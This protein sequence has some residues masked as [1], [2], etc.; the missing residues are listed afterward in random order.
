MSNSETNSPLLP[1]KKRGETEHNHGY[2]SASFSSGVFSIS[3][4]IVGAGIMALPAT[5]LITGLIPG[6]VLIMFTG[7]L[8]DASLD[9]LLKYSAPARATT[10]SAV[11]AD[12]FG[13]TGQILSQICIIIFNFGLLVI[14]LIIMGKN[15]LFIPLLI[16]VSAVAFL[17]LTNC[18]MDPE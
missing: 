2:K 13:R 8:T 5:L 6:L 7:V 4:S 10:Y 14:Y 16:V 12:T 18:V 3:T 9:F 1:L 17:D 15:C 11:V